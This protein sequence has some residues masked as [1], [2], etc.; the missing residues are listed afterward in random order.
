MAQSSPVLCFFPD[1]FFLLFPSGKEP[2]PGSAIV[3]ENEPPGLVNKLY[4]IPP[5]HF[6]L[7]STGEMKA[8]PSDTLLL[9]W[10]CVSHFPC[11]G[12]PHLSHPQRIYRAKLGKGQGL[13]LSRA[14][15][16]A[17]GSVLSGPCAVMLVL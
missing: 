1:S 8:E 6:G 4:V 16:G 7:G 17:G 5:C 12:P 10:S 14:V 11:L 2:Q 9:T 15:L 13:S 3:F